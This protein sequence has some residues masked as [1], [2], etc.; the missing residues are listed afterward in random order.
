MV[1][2][3]VL[4]LFIIAELCMALIAFGMLDFGIA[5]DIMERMEN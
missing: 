4:I 3:V 5:V 1:Q 2:M